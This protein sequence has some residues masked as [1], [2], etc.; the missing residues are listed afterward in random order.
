[1]DSSYELAHICIKESERVLH[2][3]TNFLNQSLLYT[4]VHVLSLVNSFNAIHRE[5]L[6]WTRMAWRNIDTF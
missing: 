4:V 3:H 5:S 2:Y 1:M 6:G